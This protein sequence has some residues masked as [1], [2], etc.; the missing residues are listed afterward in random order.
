MSPSKSGVLLNARR[1]NYSAELSEPVVQAELE[2]VQV[3]IARSA[4]KGGGTVQ[5]RSTQAFAAPVR[6]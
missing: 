3:H 2:H 5:T 6:C 1:V 4:A